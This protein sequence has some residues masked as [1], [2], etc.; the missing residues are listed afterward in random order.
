MPSSSR[1][2]ESLKMIKT[3]IFKTSG[4]SKPTS[5]RNNLEDKF[6]IFHSVHYNYY[7]LHQQMHTT[8]LELWKYNKN[9]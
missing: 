9:H 8:V 1:V 2:E 4:I 5:Q 6:H 7:N 3:Q